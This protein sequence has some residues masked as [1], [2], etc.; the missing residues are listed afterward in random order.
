MILKLSLSVLCLTLC[1]AFGIELN[2]LVNLFGYLLSVC[3]CLAVYHHRELLVKYIVLQAKERL[4][5]LLLD[6]K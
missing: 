4:H 2:Y 3:E 1:E 6:S 5:E